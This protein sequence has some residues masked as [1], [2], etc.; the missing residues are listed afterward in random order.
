[1]RRVE[2]FEH[3]VQSGRGR[4]AVGVL[5][6]GAQPGRQRGLVPRSGDCRPQAALDW[7]LR[8]LLWL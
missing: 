7:R 3:L 4:G 5:L 1:M 8:P 2:V 6:R